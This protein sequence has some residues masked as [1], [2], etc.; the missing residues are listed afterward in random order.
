MKQIIKLIFL[1]LWSILA[2]RDLHSYINGDYK[3]KN[4][5]INLMITIIC[6]AAVLKNTI[7]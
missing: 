1:A 2:A 5:W 4:G 7:D 3:M 6:L